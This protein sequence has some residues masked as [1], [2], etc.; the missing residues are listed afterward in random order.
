MRAMKA[1][2]TA[3]STKSQPRRH[4]FV[5]KARE[6]GCDESEE[7]FDATLRKIGKAKVKEP[8]GKPAKE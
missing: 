1:T 7:A 2:K 3:K 5:D 6:L 4:A 8:E